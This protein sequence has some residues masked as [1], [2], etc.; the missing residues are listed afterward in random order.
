VWY[1]ASGKPES[2]YASG[3]LGG[4]PWW[5][6]IVTELTERNVFIVILSPEA[7][8]SHWVH[9]EIDLAWK[10]R[11]VKGP[12]RGKVI[13][14]LLH[15]PCAIPE[16]L[17]LIQ[18][19]NFL[20]P[21]PYEA[22]FTELLAAIRLGET[23]MVEQPTVEVGPPFDLALLPLPAHFVGREQ[24]LAFLSERLAIKGST[25]GIAAVNGLGG[26]GKTGLAAKVVRKLHDEG[27]FPDGIAVA[28][29]QDKRSEAEALQLIVDVLTR[30]DPQRHAPEATDYAGLAESAR[31]LLGGHDALVVLDNVEPEL[32]LAMVVNPLR[33]AGVTLLLT[34]RQ[35]QPPDLVPPEGRL[36]LELLTEE[37]ALALLA[38]SLGHPSAQNLTPDNLAA[39]RR[40]VLALDCHT[41]A[42]TLAAAYVADAVGVTLAGLAAELAD[43]Q[44]GLRLPKGEA[45]AEV[46][47]VF[48][49]SYEALPPDA[50]RLFAALA[51]LPTAE[52]GRDAVVALA[53]ALGV[54]DAEG[55]TELLVRRAL[56]S[57]QG[58]RLRVHP[59]LQ[60]LSA[61]EFA[62][63]PL[64]E[65]T[66][67]ERAVV[68]YYAEYANATPD[69]A[70]APEEANILGAIEWAQAL[71]EDRLV[72][73]LCMG[74]RGFWRDTG[75]TRTALRYLPWGMAAAERVAS[76][77]GERDDL[78]AQIDLA[79][80]YGDT[81]WA[82]GRMDE[83]EARYR[84]DLA[85]TRKLVDR[86]GEARALTRL[87]LVASARG[88]VDE[89]QAYYE[90]SL[91]FLREMGDRGQ[92]GTTLN[93]LALVAQD[94]GQL[95]EAQ[96]YLEQS[97]TISREIGDRRGEGTTLN[98]L[99]QVAQ[100]RGQL[101]EAQ[102]YYQQSLAIL[103]EVGDRRGE[104][105]TLNNLS[106]V[107]Q[108]RGQLDEAQDYLEQSLAIL[109]EV[110]DRRGEGAA[111]NNL[112]RAAQAR[113]Q[114]AEAQEYFVQSMTIAQETEYAELE[115][116]ARGNVAEIARLRS[117]QEAGEP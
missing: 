30:F 114:L 19:V 107:A 39:A 38:Q 50:K 61:G 59:L 74:V 8:E 66:Q 64:A 11:N 10:Q 73:Q 52:C 7:M 63:W 110:G 58:E 31:L 33:E 98:N 15:Q 29:C 16:A 83:A 41:L 43:P 90:E 92:E 82:T 4:D 60:A 95:D 103:L 42:V 85:S 100:A 47:R 21:H 37:E 112:G 76:V 55:M 17:S 106:Q 96:D 56:L 113:G 2:H 116:A 68:A 77:T 102:D 18:V 99:S 70:L 1:D 36:T 109:R 20:P 54:A 9:D 87:G 111:L 34:A 67:T 27:R 40:I 86:G 49:T 97:L 105:T 57:L 84:Q 79:Q 25:S 81:L 115:K 35:K 89:A 3:L 75:R 32:P 22:A 91:A 117:S 101:D 5:S 45:P 104:G 51:A 72:A 6:R 12:K 93:S 13:I 28:R 23:R 53:R 26:I 88:R 78:I 46:R 65:R 48:A 44:R 62:A 108:A 71:G 24:E 94:R 14:P 69:L 80:I